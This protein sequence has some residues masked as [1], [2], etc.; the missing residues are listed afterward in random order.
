MKK[1][2]T[3]SLKVLQGELLEFVKNKYYNK[4]TELKKYV[5][6]IDIKYRENLIRAEKRR[7]KKKSLG[8][9]VKDIF[10]KISLKT[11]QLCDKLIMKEKVSNQIMGYAEN[12]DIADAEKEVKKGIDEW[13]K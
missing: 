7:E 1:E 4:D 2:K 13:T 3:K 9:K 12:P 8:E 6:Q 10:V 11:L 5:D